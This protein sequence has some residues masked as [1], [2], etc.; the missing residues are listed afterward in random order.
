M[1]LYMHDFSIESVGKESHR[2]VSSTLFMIGD[3]TPRVFILHIC[4]A[5]SVISLSFYEGSLYVY[6]FL[7]LYLFT[8]SPKPYHHGGYAVTTDEEPTKTYIQ[9]S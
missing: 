3:N 9:Q 8:A 5:F 1:P 2:N 6:S 7:L 4:K